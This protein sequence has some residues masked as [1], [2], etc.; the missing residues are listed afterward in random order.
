MLF[1][2][3]WQ[4]LDTA[5]QKLLLKWLHPPFP[6]FPPL[7]NPSFLSC[8]NHSFINPFSLSYSLIQSFLPAFFPLTTLPLCLS[9]P[10]SRTIIHPRFIL[11]FSAK[12]HFPLFLLQPLLLPSSIYYVPPSVLP[13]FPFICLFPFSSFLH[14]YSFQPIFFFSLLSILPLSLFHISL[15]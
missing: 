5:V 7:W 14:S 3:Q 12:A 13:V 10:C 15:T 11:S 2:L 6:L 1:S 9:F 8:I 4:L